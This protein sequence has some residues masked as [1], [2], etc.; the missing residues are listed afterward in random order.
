MYSKVLRDIFIK[1]SYT[2]NDKLQMIEFIREK[3]KDNI[4]ELQKIE[5]FKSEYESKKAIYCY[6]I[7]GFLYRMINKALRN[8]DFIIFDIFLK[9]FIYN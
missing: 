7:D 2:E 4:I 8:Q 6:T 9:I 5:N 1:H 3:Y